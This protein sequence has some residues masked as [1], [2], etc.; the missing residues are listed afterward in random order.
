MNNSP[1]PEHRQ[2]RFRLRMLLVFVS[3][4]NTLFA[5]RLTMRNPVTWSMMFMLTALTGGCGKGPDTT[6][7]SQK[8]PVASKGS[9]SGNL[10]AVSTGL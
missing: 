8:V 6:G 7:P 4:A 5:R 9:P 3:E 10:R 1:K 2:Y